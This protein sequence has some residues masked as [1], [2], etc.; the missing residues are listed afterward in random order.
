MKRTLRAAL[1]L[2]LATS[3]AT[4][5]LAERGNGGNIYLPTDRAKEAR[6]GDRDGDR[7]RKEY[8]R[9]DHDRDG[10]RRERRGDRDRDRDHDRDRDRDRDRR[11]YRDDDDRRGDY[12]RCPPG[13]ARKHNGCQPPG[14]ARKHYRRGEYLPRD[15][16][17][18]SDYD[19]YRLERRD[20]WD[21]YRDDDRIY[22]VDRDTRKV[23]AVIDLINAFSN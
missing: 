16:H 4:P 20:S 10:D 23:L 2:A 15:Y 8:R 18:I 1:I 19:R 7:D 17:R 6:R 11:K 21:Y 13:L 9:R 5:A 14:H 3:V 12:R 22:R